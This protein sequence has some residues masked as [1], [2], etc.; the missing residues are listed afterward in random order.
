MI[1]VLKNI[2]ETYNYKYKNWDKNVM[3]QVQAIFTMLN[4]YYG[5]DRSIQKFVLLCDRYT[6]IDEVIDLIDIS[7]DICE[8][9]DEIEA[10]DETYVASLYRFWDDSVIVM[11]TTKDLFAELQRLA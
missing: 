11:V 7:D 5:K 6:T 8:W 4:E 3:R 10:C 2:T 1:D 9:T